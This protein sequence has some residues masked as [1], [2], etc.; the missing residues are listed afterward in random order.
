MPMQIF[1]NAVIYN[2]DP[3]S[4]VHVMA[5]YLLVRALFPIFATTGVCLHQG[6]SL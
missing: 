2:T 5:T 4:N 1:A 6:M 3:E